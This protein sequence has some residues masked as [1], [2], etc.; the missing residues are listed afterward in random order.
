MLTREQILAKSRGEEIVD[1]PSGGQVRVRGLSRDEALEVREMEANAD[2]DN[3]LVARGL[4]DPV[5][6]IDD[7]KAWAALPGSAGDIA[8][9]GMTIGHLSGFS[10]GAGKSGVPKP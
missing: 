9:I 10:E 5:M 4:V 6:S 8:E 1:L 7:V 2:R 3:V